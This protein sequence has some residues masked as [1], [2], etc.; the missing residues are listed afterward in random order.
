MR[1]LAII[2]ALL[3]VALLFLYPP[4]NEQADGECS[5]L[6]QR[7]MDIASHD[8]SG[9]LIVSQLYGSTSSAPSGANFARD[10]YPLLPTTLGCTL[11][12]W[13]T[14]FGAPLPVAIGSSLP[15]SL[16]APMPP[17][18]IPAAVPA[19]PP[20]P[21]AAMVARGITPN[22]DPISPETSF[23]LPMPAV[24]IRAPY[25]ASFTG[26]LSFQLRQGRAVLSSCPAE[27]AGHAIAWCKF[28]IELRKGLYSISLTANSVV[29]GQYA[30]AV[31]GR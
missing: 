25:P 13:R 20:P 21:P 30:F 31:I 29:L 12:Y 28:N 7:I 14:A 24:A 15:A 4:L 16:P 10:Q 22:G 1:F 26:A 8:A 18:A 19:E 17:S 11:A 23:T 6:E 5:A 2:A 27:K 9:A 3:A